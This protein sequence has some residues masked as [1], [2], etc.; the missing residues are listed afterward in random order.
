LDISHSPLLSGDN[1]R[2]SRW[3]ERGRSYHHVRRRFYELAAAGPAPIA[4]EALE[5]I[6]AL[7]AIEAEIRGQD[8]P[9]R[10]TARQASSRPLVED[11]E[12]WL[13]AK[14]TTISQKTKLAEAIRYALSRWA[15]LTFFLGDGRIELDNNIVERSIRPLALTRKN[16]LFAGSDG[17]ADHWAILASLIETAKLNDVD[18]QAYISSVITRIVQGHPQSRIDQL[19][20]WSYQA[21][22]AAVV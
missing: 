19:L 10:H 11:L 6:K 5:Q 12:P 21:K 17:G 1:C 2:H 7:Y 3:G 8:H 20:P 15:G 22:A 16:S 13:R 9:A 14:L 4:T 18:P